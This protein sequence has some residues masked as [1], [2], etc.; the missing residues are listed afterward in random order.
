MLNDPD[1]EFMGP[2]IQDV[3]GVITIIILIYN[4]LKENFIEKVQI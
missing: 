3:L 1:N 2:P 4:N